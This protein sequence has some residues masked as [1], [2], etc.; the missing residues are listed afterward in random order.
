MRHTGVGALPL[1]PSA[2]PG[3]PPPF[4]EDQLLEECSKGVQALYE[5]LKTSQDS[6]KIVSDLLGPPPGYGGDQNRR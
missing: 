4:N 2:A 6:A 3:T 1:L 5:K